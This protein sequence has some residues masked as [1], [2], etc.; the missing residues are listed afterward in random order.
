MELSGSGINTSGEGG[1]AIQLQAARIFS[2]TEGTFS[3]ISADTQGAIDGQGIFIR[4]TDAL[5]LEDAAITA[6]VAPGSTSNGGNITVESPT[7]SIIGGISSILTRNFGGG[8]AGDIAITTHQFQTLEGAG[9]LT[10]TLGPGDGGNLTI[11]ATE[12]VELS[13]TA[14]FAGEEQ[15]GGLSADIRGT[16]TGGRLTVTTGQLTLQDGANISARTNDGPGG[17]I[18]IAA[19]DVDLLGGS[20]QAQTFGRGDAG[21]ITI[22][23]QRLSISDGNEITAT[24]ILPAQG[25]AGNIDVIASES[26]DATGVG[27]L[28]TAVIGPGNGGD[29]TIQTGDLTLRDGA[30]ITAQAFFT[31][32]RGGSVDVTADRIEVSGRDGNVLFPSQIS[33]TTSSGS[34]EAAGDLTLNTRELLVSNGGEISANTLGGNAAG[35]LV[36]FADDAIEV[37]GTFIDSAGEAAPSRISAS[38]SAFGGGEGGSVTL[39]TQRLEVSEG[40]EINVSSQGEGAA[41]NLTVN[42]HT[43]RLLDAGKVIATSA[44]GDGGNLIFQ[45][46]E[47]LLLRNGSQISTSAGTAQT[48]GDGG[49]ITITAPFVVAIPEEDSDITA[50]AFLGS[51][52]SVNIFATGIF[53]LE[54]R[55]ETTPLS[56][57]TASS[58]F[59]TTGD[60]NLNALDTDFI[61]DTLTELPESPVTTDRLLAGS[62]IAQAEGTQGSFVITGGDSLP[63]R[64]GDSSTSAFQTGEVRSLTDDAEVDTAAGWQRGDPMVEPAGIYQLA[65][66]RIV[67]SHPCE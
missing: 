42:A 55:P 62:C 41:G 11:T 22:R 32:G 4:A 13:G 46:D 54:F 23:T 66:G 19:D 58:D 60:V 57:I 44:S 17:S 43:L 61:E 29:L 63:T 16:G 34:G 33:T 5:F 35:N 52:G 49:N 67:L 27:G 24:S 64:P 3:G 50:N 25:D 39:T 26:I 48:F 2:D 9:V 18:F 65:D 53:G 7:V 51:G 30:N 14:I 38:T 15:A 10:S 56:D 47:S 36:I 12:S 21:D 20:I 31:F 8:R 6:T 40:A 28:T 1:G 45:L 37:T 59:G